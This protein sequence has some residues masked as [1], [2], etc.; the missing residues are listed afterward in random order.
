MKTGRTPTA[1]LRERFPLLSPAPPLPPPDLSQCQAGSSQ[2]TKLTTHLSGR[3]L[4]SPQ[5]KVAKLGSGSHVEY[6]AKTT[7]DGEQYK[8]YPSTFPS[9]AQAEEA[10]AGIALVKLGLV[11]QIH[12]PLPTL[13]SRSPPT[14]HSRPPPTLHSRPPLTLHSRPPP[15]LHSRPPPTLNSRRPPTLG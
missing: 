12:D 1:L 5:F 13:H 4:P 3:G 14:L 6:M 10:V 2:R 8:T 15:T 11:N 9:Q 7:V